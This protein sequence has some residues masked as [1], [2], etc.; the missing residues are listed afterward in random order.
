LVKR[1]RNGS[2]YDDAY[3]TEEKGS[4]VKLATHLVWDA[5]HHDM[6]VALVMS[7]DSDLQESLD[8]P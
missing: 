4:D 6:D 1:R 2:W 7:N 8:M 3:I 5:A